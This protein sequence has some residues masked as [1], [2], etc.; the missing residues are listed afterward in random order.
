MSGFSLTVGLW[1]VWGFLT[2][3][4]LFVII[5]GGMFVLSAIP[6]KVLNRKDGKGSKAD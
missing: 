6:L 4:L 1:P 5:M 3:L 2:P